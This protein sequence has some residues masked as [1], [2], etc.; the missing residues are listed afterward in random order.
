MMSQIS[1][2]GQGGLTDGSWPRHLKTLQ[3]FST[4]AVLFLTADK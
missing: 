1:L 4:F 3:G 2:G